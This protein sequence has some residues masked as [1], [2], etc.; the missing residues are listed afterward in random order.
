[1]IGIRRE[2][3][4]ATSLT[5]LSGV[6]TA[7]GAL[8]P[9]ISA[10]GARPFIGVAHTSFSKMLVYTFAEGSFFRSV[11]AV[12]FVLGALMV[13]GSLVASRALLASAALLALAAGGMWI[14]LVVH[15]FNTPNLPNLHYVNPA[16]LPWLDL[17]VGAWLTTGGAVF[18][19]LGAVLQR[20]R[21][22]N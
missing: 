5:A 22:E 2:Q 7:V 18:G 15:H 3:P 8:L 20:R 4:L 16:N 14:G 17:R 6:A 12:V 13:V 11:G 9:W 1:M 19:L 21:T 10:S